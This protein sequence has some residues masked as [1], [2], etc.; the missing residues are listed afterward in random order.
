MILP[1]GIQVP[2]GRHMGIGPPKAVWWEFVC[3]LVEPIIV[4]VSR[5]MVMRRVFFM[6]KQL[7]LI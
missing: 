3:V 5:T 4:E 1:F 6:E 7:L 2:S